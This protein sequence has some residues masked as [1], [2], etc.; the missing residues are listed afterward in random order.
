MN[1]VLFLLTLFV[2]NTVSYQPGDI[3]YS[4]NFHSENSLK[5]WTPYPW[6]TLVSGYD[7]NLALQVIVPVPASGPPA[8][9]LTCSSLDLSM[10]PGFV[11][12]VTALVKE[13]N[14]TEPSASYSDVAHCEHRW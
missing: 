11:V 13:E 1:G 7:G 12:F 8:T 9:R 10:A 14:V 3:L 6:A 4:I 2:C 5:G